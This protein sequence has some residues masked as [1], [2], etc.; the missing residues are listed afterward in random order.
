M[1][2]IKSA[3]ICQTLHFL[4]KEELGHDY[5]VS[6]VR[7]EVANYK[8]SLEKNRTRYKNVSEHEEEDGSVIIEIIKQYNQSPVGNYL[9]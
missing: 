7:Q 9:K 8:Q 2:R 1:R 5:A 4:L 6:L 3:C